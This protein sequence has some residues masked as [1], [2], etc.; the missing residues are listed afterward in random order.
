[1]KKLLSV[2]FGWYI[3]L[4]EFTSNTSTSTSML[5]S[6]FRVSTH[7]CLAYKGCRRHLSADDL[8]ILGLPAPVRLS[9][10]SWQ[11][12]FHSYL[13]SPLS[14]TIDKA[15]AV[16]QLSRDRLR[17]W[18]IHGFATTMKTKKSSVSWCKHDNHAPHSAVA[19]QAIM[20]FEKVF[21]PAL[22]GLLFCLYEG[23]LHLVSVLLTF[24]P[25]RRKRLILSFFRS[26]S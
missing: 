25:T 6:I 24:G 7:P 9:L 15:I 3:S 1:M 22:W 2:R 20:H 5:K 13:K 14:F 18:K 12:F 23:F 16:F 19:I 21:L 11:G 8:D 17:A 10:H 26:H 4:K